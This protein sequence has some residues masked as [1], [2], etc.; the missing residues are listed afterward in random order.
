MLDYV[1]FGII[2]VVLNVAANY[3]KYLQLLF[4]VQ[5]KSAKMF[6]KIKCLHCQ[7]MAAVKY[8]GPILQPLVF[9]HDFIGLVLVFINAKHACVIR[10]GISVCMQANKRQG[11]II[12]NSLLTSSAAKLLHNNKTKIFYRK[13]TMRSFTTHLQQQKTQKKVMQQLKKCHNMD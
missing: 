11:A 1:I 7:V 3:C 6:S 5:V 8:F 2:K 4:A 9:E 13:S 10:G 12:I